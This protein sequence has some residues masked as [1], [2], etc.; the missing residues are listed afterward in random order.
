MAFYWLL[1]L[2]IYLFSHHISPT[3]Q[4]EIEYVCV[5]IYKQPAFQ[6][7]SMKN[8]QI[9]MR[10]SVEFQAM[11]SMEPETSDM[12]TSS[13][14]EERCPK[15]QVPIHKPQSNYTNNFI[16]PE[17]TITAAN[18]H[19]AIIKTFDNST[20][21]FGGAQAV[22]SIYKPRVLKNQF[23]KAWVWLNHREKDMISSIQFGWAVHTGLYRDDRPRLTTFSV[24]SKHQNGCYNALCPGGYV[25]VHKTIYPGM[26]YDKVSV[27]GKKQHDVH[28]LVGQDSKT[29]SWLLMTR[30]TLIGYWPSHMYSMEG[31]SQIY[32]GGYTEGPTGAISPPMGAGTFPREVN[33]IDNLASFMKQLKSFQDKSLVDIN[34]HSFEEYVDSPKCYDVWYR[35]FELGSGEMLTFGGPGGVCGMV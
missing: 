13:K 34:C 15:G 19:Y 26:V 8:H 7:P 27:V 21:R 28:L 32:F 17:T 14:S 2:F 35:E 5:D 12:I 25:Q 22:F 11:L 4:G 10:P 30:K 1:C 29:K 16:H 31:A 9:Q 3:V 33:R 23:S 24:G 18:L 6:H 20:E